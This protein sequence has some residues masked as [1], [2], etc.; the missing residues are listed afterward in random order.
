[1]RRIAFSIKFLTALIVLGS[2][3][4]VF[5]TAQSTSAATKSSCLNQRTSKPSIRVSGNTAT[6]HFTIPKNCKEKVVLASYQAPNGT[7]GKPYEK[8]KIYRWVTQVYNK[9]GN[10]NL[11]VNIPNCFY[12]VDLARGDVIQRFSGD[13]TYNR[14]GRLLAHK[15]GGN[16]SCE[17]KPVPTP[18]PTPTPQPQPPKP[19]VTPP[20]QNNIICSNIYVK[21][22]SKSGTVP[23]TYQF[24][25]KMNGQDTDST[26]YNY[27]FGDGKTAQTE[28]S[29]AAHTYTKPG[30]Y[31]GKMTP[32]DSSNR[33][34]NNQVACTFT[35]VVSQPQTPVTPTTPSTPTTPEVPTTPEE[36]ET[37]QPT[38]QP[39][40]PQQ[41]EVTP[42]ATQTKVSDEATAP[43]EPAQAEQSAGKLPDTGPG[44]IAAI[45]FASTFMGSMLF[46][47]R[48]RMDSILATIVSRLG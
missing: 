47:Y 33:T 48:G 22:A 28:D 14:Q 10:Y 4:P 39:V 32:S 6:A 17:P 26:S 18:T 36:P 46:A 9:P 25:P 45:G 15:Q 20:N 29:T 5:G 41:E 16:K 27:D 38:P 37:T 1:M 34:G 30:K 21:K 12:Q 23:A 3:I 43:E 13:N 35:V 7:H 2:A 44:D 31:K 19:V 8:Q 42:A 24:T 40:E 11:K